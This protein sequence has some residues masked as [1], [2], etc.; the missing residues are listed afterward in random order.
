MFFQFPIPLSQNVVKIKSRFLAV[1]SETW[2]WRVIDRKASVIIATLGFF[3]S[4]NLKTEFTELCSMQAFSHTYRAHFSCFSWSKSCWCCSCDFAHRLQSFA[5]NWHFLFV[6]IIVAFLLAH[7]QFIWMAG[8]VWWTLGHVFRRWIRCIRCSLCC[9]CCV[10]CMLF[11][12]ML[13]SCCRLFSFLSRWS[14][15]ALMIKGIN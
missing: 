8:E 14:T 13:P 5:S 10:C 12:F 15:I 7:K 2:V 3:L 6:V 4:T 1:F 11:Y 9:C